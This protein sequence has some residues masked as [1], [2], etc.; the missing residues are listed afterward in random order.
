MPF[1]KIFLLS[2]PLALLLFV[3]WV[4]FA[5]SG[6]SP[7]YSP[8]FEKIKFSNEETSDSVFIKKKVWGVL[9]NHQIIVIS[10]NG[11]V[12]FSPDSTAD[13]VFD[14]W[15]PFFYKFENDTL[16]TFVLKE[17]QSPVSFKSG[18]TVKQNVLS[19]PEMINLI[20]TYQDK[21]IILFAR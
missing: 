13:Y 1:K 9:A 14:S 21:G 12:P 11:K 3:A 2:I 20:E 4:Y 19:S 17:S 7:D 10:K 16:F 8:T 18:I 5:I 15:S 6:L